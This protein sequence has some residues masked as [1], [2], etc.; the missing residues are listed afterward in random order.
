MARLDK[1][2][3]KLEDMS[4]IDRPRTFLPEVKNERAL[5]DCPEMSANTMALRP[6]RVMMYRWWTRP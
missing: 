3:N 1:L 2:D 6:A 4:Q 5:K